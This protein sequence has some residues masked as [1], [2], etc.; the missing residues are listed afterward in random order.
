MDVAFAFDLDTSTT[1]HAATP[2]DGMHDI[3]SLGSSTLPATVLISSNMRGFA[4]QAGLPTSYD[5]TAAS[6]GD[7]STRI[8][9][10]SDKWR[11]PVIAPVLCVP[12]TGIHFLSRL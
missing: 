2:E 4:N 1:S 7:A 12:P 5:F 3:C 11:H 8:R 10:D 6:E 9:N